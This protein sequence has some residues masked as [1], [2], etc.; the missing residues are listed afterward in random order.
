VARIDVAGG[1]RGVRDRQPA[2]RTDDVDAAP[3][4]R[5]ARWRSLSTLSP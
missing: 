2:C 4:T 3:L 5:L 1:V